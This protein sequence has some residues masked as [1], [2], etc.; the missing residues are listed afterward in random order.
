MAFGWH[1][2]GQLID[3]KEDTNATDSWAHNLVSEANKLVRCLHPLRCILHQ[4]LPATSN[5]YLPELQ[6]VSWNIL[7]VPVPSPG[8][9][10]LGVKRPGCEADHSPPTSAEVKEWVE[11]YLHSPNTPT[12]RGAKIKAQ[13]Q[14]YVY[15]CP[16]LQVWIPKE[17]NSY[18]YFGEVRVSVRPSRTW[19]GRFSCNSVWTPCQR[20]LLRLQTFSSEIPTCQK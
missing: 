5:S 20:R 8:A 15:F 18:S 6:P 14:L 11:L 12:W 2:K 13:G 19:T 10:S 17:K 7:K 16:Y 9:L 1:C 4:A 3:L